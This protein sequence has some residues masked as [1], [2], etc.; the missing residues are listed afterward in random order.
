MGYHLRPPRKP[1]SQLHLIYCATRRVH[2]PATIGRARQ[3]GQHGSHPAP[4]GDERGWR[5][6]RARERGPVR[7][8]RQEAPRP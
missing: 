3:Q 4:L 7:R 6:R 2:G 1:T 5:R 8:G